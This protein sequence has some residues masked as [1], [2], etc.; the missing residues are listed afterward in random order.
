MRGNISEAV[1][2]SC[3]AVAL[4]IDRFTGTCI[5]RTCILAKGHG[6]RHL[7][8]SGCAITPKPPVY[9]WDADD[10]TPEL[11]TDHR[12]VDGLPLIVESSK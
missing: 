4:G 11:I 5:P 7:A 1:A 9:E 8:R 2:H 3:K 6:G 10:D 12:I